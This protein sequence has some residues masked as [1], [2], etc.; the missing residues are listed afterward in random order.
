VVRVER[1]AVRD[2][3]G[4]DRLQMQVDG[5]VFLGDRW[6][7]HLARGTLRVVAHGPAPLEQGE[8][9]CEIPP[10]DLWIFPNA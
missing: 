7:H 10:Q 3:P 4:P 1:V 6:E 2:A 9:W 5:S 8:V